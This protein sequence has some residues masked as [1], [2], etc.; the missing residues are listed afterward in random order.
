M[1]TPCLLPF[2]I[3]QIK[4]KLWNSKFQSLQLEA[5]CIIIQKESVFNKICK[6]DKPVICPNQIASKYGSLPDQSIC[7][8]QV[9]SEKGFFLFSLS[10][11]IRFMY[12]ATVNN[13]WSFN[14]I[15]FLFYVLLLNPRKWIQG[16]IWFC[17]FP[18]SAENIRVILENN[19]I[20]L[21]TELCYNTNILGGRWLSNQV[22]P[23]W[24]FPITGEIFAHCSISLLPYTHNSRSLLSK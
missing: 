19:M 23:C 20:L 8:N 2:S 7:K 18:V 3:L 1:I 24:T 11:K 13:F 10:P 22:N 17:A 6:L 9:N 5:N 16:L 21:S 4:W 14:L 12:S 15:L